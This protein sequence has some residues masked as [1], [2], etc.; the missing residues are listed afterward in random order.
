MSEVRVLVIGGVR[1]QFIKIAA[2]QWNIE[3]FNKNSKTPILATYVNT[4][5]HYDAT[6][7]SNIINELNIHFDHSFTYSTNDPIEILGIMFIKLSKLLD[8]IVPKPDLV[9]VMGDTTTTFVGATVAVRKGFPLVH[10]EAGVRSGDINKVEEMHRRVVSHLTTIHFCT[11][12]NS[13]KNLNKENITKNIYWTGDM[14]Y[15]YIINCSKSKKNHFLY[16]KRNYV[17]ATLHKPLNLEANDTLENILSALSNYSREVLFICHPRLRIK[18]NEMGIQDKLG[19]IQFIDALPYKQMIHAIKNCGFILT[20]SGGLQR[21]AYYLKK[22]CLI[23]RDTLG[24]SIFVRNQ[25]H[26]LIGEDKKS[27]LDGLAWVEDS[28]NLDYPILDNQFIRPDSAFYALNKLM[29]FRRN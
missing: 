28:L 13:E 12:R 17:L 11:S 25:I 19:K 5:Q 7:S 26:H 23:R 3:Q 14:S 21:E 2:L 20:D 1:P 27:I 8:E 10:M 16:D 4:G 9:M 24:W 6:L 22:R 18:L 15:D 29:E